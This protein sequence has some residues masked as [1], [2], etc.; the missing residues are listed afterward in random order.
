M[1]YKMNLWSDSFE[2]VKSGLKTIEMRLYDEKRALIKIDDIIEFV[3]VDTNE[4][5]KCS[6]QNIYLYKTF[7]E[8]YMNHDKIAIGYTKDE[9]ADSKDMLLYYS[10]DKIDKYGVMG[11]EINVIKD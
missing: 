4:I 7:N 9:I 6:V 5:L 8:L 11:I 1:S 10:Q 3:N 2:A